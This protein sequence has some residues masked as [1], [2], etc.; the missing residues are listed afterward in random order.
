MPTPKRRH[1]KQ[2]KNHRVSSKLKQFKKRLN[3]KDFIPP[4][5]RSTSS[6]K[7]K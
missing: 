6:N 2:R 3:L 1:S 4:H 5:L 7:N